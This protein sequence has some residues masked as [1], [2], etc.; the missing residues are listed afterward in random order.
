VIGSDFIVMV[1]E[2]TPFGLHD[3]RIAVEAVSALGIPVG[4][5]VNRAGVGD[6]KVQEFCRTENIPIL[7]EIPH[8]RRIAEAYAAGSVI[9]EAVP[10]YTPIFME[11]MAIV[12]RIGCTNQRGP[13]PIRRSG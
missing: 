6:E 9:V 8:D 12:E 5:V 2:P 10:Q 7:A 1:T 13:Q 4:V 11:M 3:L